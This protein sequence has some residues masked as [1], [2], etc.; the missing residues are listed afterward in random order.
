M[1]HCNHQ[2]TVKQEVAA[3]TWTKRLSDSAATS[4]CSVF[5]LYWPS[6]KYSFVLT[7]INLGHKHTGTQTNIKLQTLMHKLTNSRPTKG[8]THTFLSRIF[9]SNSHWTHHKRLPLSKSGF[10]YSILA[11]HFVCWAECTV[12][13]EASYCRQKVNGCFYI[14][15]SGMLL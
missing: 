12:R 14:K 3:F 5:S 6:G 13:R 9:I 8:G 10:I 1:I 4:C 15:W 7:N 2:I 11:F